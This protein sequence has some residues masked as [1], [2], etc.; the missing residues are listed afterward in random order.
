[1]SQPPRSRCQRP[2]GSP[3]P[4]REVPGSSS[5][6]PSRNRAG[7]SIYQQPH[8]QGLRRDP[9]PHVRAAQIPQGLRT[10]CRQSRRNNAEY[11]VRYGSRGYQNELRL[12]T[13]R[14]DCARARTIA[15]SRSVATDVI[16]AA[17]AERP[18][19]AGKVRCGV[20]GWCG[21]W[22]WLPGREAE[23]CGVG[24]AVV[25]S[26]HLAEAAWPA[27]G[28]AAADLTGRD[29]NTG[30]GHGEAAG[31]WAAHRLHAATVAEW[32]CAVPHA[33]LAAKQCV[34]ITA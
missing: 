13:E 2:D 7:I 25:L 24:S 6:L 8:C 28:G 26:E 20:G 30:N 12:A 33:L 27:G 9:C 14:R 31:T 23:R 34:W 19:S 32:P 15:G 21:L 11:P 1:M 3:G 4:T 10:L 22:D 16:W 5:P 18:P 17:H 29:R